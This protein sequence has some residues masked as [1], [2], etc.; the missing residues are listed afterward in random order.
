M[1]I[2]GLAP[3]EQLP[4][5]ST[6]DEIRQSLARYVGADEEGLELWLASPH[7]RLGGASPQELLEAGEDEF[8]VQFVRHMVSGA[9]A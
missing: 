1:R 2:E 6:L 7:P 3:T 5:A 9:T 8:V 4:A